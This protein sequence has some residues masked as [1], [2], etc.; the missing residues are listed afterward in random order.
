[1]QSTSQSIRLACAEKVIITLEVEQLRS[2]KIPKPHLEKNDQLTVKWIF[3]TV[4]ELKTEVTELQ[5]TL[6]SSVILQN[7][8][9]V[10]TKFIY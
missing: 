10:E 3:N 7:H 4:E 5:T 1:M 9:R 8:E 6:N 2:G